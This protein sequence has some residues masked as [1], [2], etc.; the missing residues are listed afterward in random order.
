MKFVVTG[1]SECARIA[2]IS[3]SMQPRIRWSLNLLQSSACAG[4]GKVGMARGGITWS[5]EP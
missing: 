4:L 1:R 3:P 2:A 5:Q